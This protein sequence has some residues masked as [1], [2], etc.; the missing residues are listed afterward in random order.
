MMPWPLV[1]GNRP[2]EQHIILNQERRV[3]I[4]AQLAES[5]EGC[6]CVNGYSHQHVCVPES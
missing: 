4:L 1:N 5:D 2:T 6:S 3:V